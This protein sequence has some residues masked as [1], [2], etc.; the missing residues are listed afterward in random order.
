MIL[1]D[2]VHGL[3]SFEEDDERIVSRLLAT[4]EVQR[5]RRI[6]QLGLT[7]MVFPGAEHTRFA[8]AIGAAHVMT[9]LLGRL[10]VVEQVLPPELRVSAEVRRDAVA[11]ALLHDIGHGPFSHLFEEV[12]PGARRHEAWSTEILCDPA[13]DVHRTLAS[14]DVDMPV[15]VSMA[16]GPSA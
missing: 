9:R 12:L 14:F 2:P 10:R 11:A 4:R 8:H 16:C 1:R 7:S 13:T 5:L 6:R 3:V 15:R